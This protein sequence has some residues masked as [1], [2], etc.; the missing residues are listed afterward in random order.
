MLNA[1]DKAREKF[2]SNDDDVAKN[3]PRYDEYNITSLNLFMII[4]RYELKLLD[5]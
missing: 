3:I 4:G 1:I 2:G 5:Y